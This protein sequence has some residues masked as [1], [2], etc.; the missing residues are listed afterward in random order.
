MFIDLEGVRG[1][2]HV[3]DVEGEIWSDFGI[4][5]QPSWVFIDAEGNAET[6]LGRL[7]EEKLTERIEALVP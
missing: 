6:V 2:N 7:G 1:F 4:V 3:A 5:S